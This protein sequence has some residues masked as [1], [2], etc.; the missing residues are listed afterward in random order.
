MGKCII[1]F[2]VDICILQSMH[3]VA[4]D[5][6]GRSDSERL[7]SPP[8]DTVIDAFPYKDSGF[9]RATLC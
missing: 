5:N 8:H 4:M 6:L 7:N 1:I 3:T 9:Y 2:S